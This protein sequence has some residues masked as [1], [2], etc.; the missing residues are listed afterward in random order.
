MAISIRSPKVEGL[1]RELAKRRGV[2]MTEAICESLEASVA[3]QNEHMLRRRALVVEIAAVCAAAPD[4]DERSM[5]EI[6]G[7]GENGAFVD[8]R[9]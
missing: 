3:D 4:L 2:G 1:A 8:G 7:Y 6:L 5:D 9:R